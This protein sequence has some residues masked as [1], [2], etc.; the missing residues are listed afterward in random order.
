MARPARPAGSVRRRNP[1]S[2]GRGAR[3]VPVLAVT[4]LAA[5]LAVPAAA[6][7]AAPAAK[8]PTASAPSQ[9]AP[10]LADKPYMGWSS[11]SL[12]ST[13]FPGYGGENWL[14]EDHVLQQADVVA[15]KLK[16]HGY[17]YVN[18]DAGWNVDN[19]HNVSDAYARPTADLKKFPHGMKYLGDQLHA[20]GLKFGVYLAVGLYQDYYN[21]GRTPIWNAPGCTTK[22]IVYPDLRKTSGWD[23][24]S[25][26]LDFASPCTT[27]YIQSEADE[28]ASWG[29][30]F[31]KIDGVGPGSNQGDAAHDNTQDIKTWHTALQNT[32][33]PIQF[34]LSWSLSHNKAD[35]WKANSN[36]WRV[37]TDVECYCSTLAT[38]NNS[39]KERWNDVV[40]WIDD[41]GPGHWNN[42]DSLDVGVGPMD[43]LTDAERQSYA[44]FWAIEA[45]P[46]YAGDDL[47]KLDKYGLS[48]LTNDEVIAVDQAGNPARPVSQATDQ[49]VWYARN[50]DGSYTVALFNMGA[51]YNDVTADF[52]D[53]GITGKA[54]VRDLWTHKS[55]GSVSGSFGASLAPHGS[56]LLRITPNK[57]SGPGVPLNVHATGD[58][59]GSVSLS[60][61]PVNSGTATTGYDV[62]ANGTRVAGTTGSAVTVT[63]LSPA[64][65]YSLT[66]V[67]HDAKGRTSAPSK[68]VA[69]TTPA[70]GGPTAYEAEAPGNTLA[71]SASVND[72]SACSGGKKVGNLGGSSSVTVNG[73]SAPKDGTYLMKLDYVDGSSGRTVVVTVNGTAIQVPLPGSNDNDWGTPQSLIVPVPLKAGANSIAFGNPS[74]Y[75]S[76]IDRITV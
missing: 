11:W 26:Q 10:A 42:L 68:A 4:A 71:G 9:A 67:A 50:T 53:L 66:V 61:L 33:R 44:T 43:G 38:W 29:V 16:S 5:A 48:L 49:Q 63:G 51:G 32:G 17:D 59:A 72:C 54:S 7:S 73:V 39:V 23:D 15:S 13:N 2:G 18:V 31:L 36:G 69:V 28:L 45:A 55:L 8:T 75:V 56:Q 70:A 47:T 74:D 65:G 60:W 41:A 64:T 46:L 25:Y 21:D 24:V 22:D 57:T 19:G 14:T 12:E 1:L 52:S 58:T 27:K 40:P 37:D 3:A 20:K 6:A 62:Y 30:D 34:V 76:D 35:V